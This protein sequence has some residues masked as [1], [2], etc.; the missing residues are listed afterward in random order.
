VQ[1]AT[2]AASGGPKEGPAPSYQYYSTFDQLNAAFPGQNFPG[3]VIHLSQPDSS[4]NPAGYYVMPPGGSL[5][6]TGDVAPPVAGGGGA[7]GAPSPAQ[8]AT[9]GPD[10]TGGGATAAG[11]TPTTSRDQQLLN[12]TG[13]SKDTAPQQ[14]VSTTNLDFG[15]FSAPVPST[16]DQQIRTLAGLSTAPTASQT[17]AAAADSGGSTAGTGTSPGT[18]SGTGTTSG[19]G[20]TG[21][22]AGGAGTGTGAGGTDG[23]GG[24]GEGGTGSGGGKTL[25][26]GAG[27]IPLP[28]R[29]PAGTTGPAVPDIP[30]PGSQALSQA[31]A[32]PAIG[33][34]PGGDVFGV[35]GKR[36]PVWNK[37]SLRAEDTSGVSG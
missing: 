10:T 37:S 19:G 29:R 17:A 16:H 32:A 25:D 30:G 27:T 1:Q 15:T 4:G 26:F 3:D 36:T 24:G 22:G 11:S 33:Y 7:G 20:G 21:T 6:G 31:L 23:T 35:L 13:L 9:T 18:G 14:G 34:S 2:D 8:G 12:L 28:Q 5:A